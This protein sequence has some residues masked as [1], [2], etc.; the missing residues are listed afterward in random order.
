MI[1]EVFNMDYDSF[2]KNKTKKTL[3]SGFD[4]DESELNNNLFPFQKFCV[5]RALRK[6][7][8]VLFD[9]CG[10]FVTEVYN[11]DVTWNNIVLF[12]KATML[13]YKDNLLPK[14]GEK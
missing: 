6:G 4:I 2:L 8:Y 13:A 9:S 5:K 3:N 7:K 1:S 14:G 12:H 10:N 11:G